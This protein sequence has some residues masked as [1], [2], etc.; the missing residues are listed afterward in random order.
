MGPD[1]ES[2]PGFFIFA[3][4]AARTA[5]LLGPVTHDKDLEMLYTRLQPGTGREQQSNACAFGDAPARALGIE[6][7]G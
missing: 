2:A 3:V 7:D 6:G 4:N 5:P 1:R